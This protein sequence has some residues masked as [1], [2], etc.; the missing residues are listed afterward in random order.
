MTTEV[1]AQDGRPAP[2]DAAAGK[3]LA[4][5]PVTGAP[6]IVSRMYGLIVGYQA[7][8]IVGVLA[9]LR[10][11][12]HLAKQALTATELARRTGCAE[13]A[14]FR[15]LRGADAIGVLSIE[16]D[17]AFA[18]TP[19]GATL[20]ADVPGSLRGL[21]ATLTAPCHYLPWGRLEEVVRTGSC[22]AQSALGSDFFGYLAEHDDELAEFS[23]AME[24]LSAMVTGPVVQAVDL[25]GARDVVDVGGGSGTLLAALLE[26]NARL[27]GTLLE[28][29]EMLPMARSLLSERGLTSRCEVIEGD[30]FKAVPEADIHVLKLVLHD[31]DDERAATILRNCARSLRPGGR[32]VIVDSVVPEDGSQPLLPLTD[33]S[34]L[35][36]LGGHERTA[37]EHEALLRTAGL[38]LDRVVETGSWVQI[39]EA[40]HA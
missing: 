16:A 2:A 22:Q 30:F 25:S 21:A 6:E 13:A 12:D 3:F 35:A 4:R 10:I 38:H 39:V 17:G 20:R 37:R 40:T 29:P 34:M 1:K 26:A 19:V 32:V 15:L 8:Q 36:I 28:R 14:L 23:A 24:G 18:L 33:L 5:L 27:Q 7:S 31:W 11:P 9:R